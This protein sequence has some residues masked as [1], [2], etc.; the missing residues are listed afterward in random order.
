MPRLCKDRGGEL[1]PADANGAKD[2]H[3]M[4]TK[5]C[6]DRRGEPRT[7]LMLTV[8]KM[9]TRAGRWWLQQVPNDVGQSPFAG[10]AMLARLMV[11][12]VAALLSSSARRSLYLQS[13]KPP[14]AAEHSTAVQPRASSN[15]G[16]AKLPERALVQCT[17]GAQRWRSLLPLGITIYQLEPCT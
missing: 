10:Q 2:G 4:D 14:S 8:P 13:T 1:H 15:C 17:A 16:P 12:R 9:D 5:L 7:P 6:N 11:Y 3:Q